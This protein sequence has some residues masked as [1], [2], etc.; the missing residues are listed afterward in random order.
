MRGRTFCALP[1]VPLLRDP[2]FAR[3][4]CGQG[5]RLG[6]AN[7]TRGKGEGGAR[8][9]KGACSPLSSPPIPVCAQLFA[10]RSE[11]LAE[12][13]HADK[14]REYE[15]KRVN[16]GCGETG[17]GYT[18]PLSHAPFACSLRAKAG[19]GR[20]GRKG[21]WGHPFMG[22]GASE[23]GARQR[24]GGVLK[25]SMHPHSPFAL[26]RLGTKG[27]GT[28]GRRG[29]GEGE[30]RGYTTANKVTCMRFVRITR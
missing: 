14:G 4:V 20:R 11:R 25:R 15:G 5:Q 12:A 21:G 9:D 7:C 22:E 8:R 28:K 2:P 27:G 29:R 16:W 3:P 18:N 1:R 17:E 13:A 6:S 19:G 30:G 10:S 24:R 26:L 23:A